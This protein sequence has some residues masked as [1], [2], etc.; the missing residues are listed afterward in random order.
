MN[1]EYPSLF[2]SE[3]FNGDDISTES[4]PRKIMPGKFVHPNHLFYFASVMRPEKQLVD[5]LTLGGEQVG[6]H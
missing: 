2:P 6:I 4:T 5:F 3:L 1:G